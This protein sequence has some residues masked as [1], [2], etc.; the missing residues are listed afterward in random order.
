MVVVEI[1]VPN[2]TKIE[3][4]EDLKDYQRTITSKAI[5]RKYGNDNNY[6]NN[7]NWNSDEEYVL[8]KETLTETKLLQDSI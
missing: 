7:L 4:S 5:R 2:G 8:D 6:E 3:V 1:F